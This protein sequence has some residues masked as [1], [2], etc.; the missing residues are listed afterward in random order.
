MVKDSSRICCWGIFHLVVFS[1]D[2]CQEYIHDK[3]ERSCCYNWDNF[4]LT[5]ITDPTRVVF[6]TKLNICILHWWDRWAN[7]RKTEIL[8]LF[9]TPK[10][11]ILTI[12]KWVYTLVKFLV[13][14][15]Y[16]LVKFLVWH[17]GCLGTS[18]KCTYTHIPILYVHQILP[19]FTSKI[20]LCV[21][22]L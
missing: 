10:T 8:M 6:R 16:T 5:T 15:V 12:G 14:T 9:N 7:L 1:P 22:L 13:C 11:E 18:N 4:A 21:K 20:Q 3:R 17:V 19:D 2:T